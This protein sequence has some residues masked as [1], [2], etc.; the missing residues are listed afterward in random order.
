MLKGL[1]V[2]FKK[3]LRK[4]FHPLRP[5]FDRYWTI[6]YYGA[7]GSCKSIH[8]AKQ[9]VALLKWMDWYYEEHPELHQAIIFTNQKFSKEIND[10][11]LGSRLYYWE[12]FDEIEDCPRVNCWK[13]KRKHRL[14]GAYLIIDDIASILPAGMRLTNW[15]RKLFSQA[16]HNGVHTIA[17]LQDPF[18]VA[19]D[20]RRYIDMCYKFTKVFGNQ[21]PV[22][23]KVPIKRI[24]GMYRRRRIEAEML[25]RYGDM[26]EQEIRAM[27]SQ[28]EETNEAL[29]E[30]GKEFE[31]VYDDTWRGSYH[32]WGRK[33][34]MIYDTTQ[35]VQKYEP[36][37]YMHKEYR[38]L[39]KDCPFKHVNHEL[40]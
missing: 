23:T 31:Q 38:C 40:V 37:G 14:H 19:I 21:D 3:W 30:Q 4:I 24:Y 32:F 28:K 39:D 9:S 25:W 33:S 13:G 16:R 8:Q 6:C 10:K 26:P 35:D 17:N 20:F 12:D 36:K 5:E 15:I 18:S 1:W 22:E 11:Y 7:R 27:L 2:K 34:A 29:K